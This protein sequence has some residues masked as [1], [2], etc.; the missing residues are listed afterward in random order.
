MIP[1]ALFVLLP[2]QHGETRAPLKFGTIT[3]KDAEQLDG[4]R[5]TIT[6]LPAL[7]A[8]TRGAGKNLVTIAAPAD[9]AMYERTVMLRG[10][11][12]RDADMGAG[13]LTVHGTL[14][15]TRHPAAVIGNAAFAP[16]TEVRLQE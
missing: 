7:P 11:R 10:N 13:K 14:R 6:F 9:T 4:Q 1:L 8:Y 16:F 5:V 2:R 15:V 3:L 12:L